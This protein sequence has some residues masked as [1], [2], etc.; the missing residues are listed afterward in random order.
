MFISLHRF[1]AQIFSSIVF[2]EDPWIS[3]FSLRPGTISHTHIQWQV[4]VRSR[5]SVVGISTGYGLDD[6]GVGIRVPVGSRI[7]F[8]PRLP[9]RFWGTPSFLSNRYRRLF[10]QGKSGG[11]VKLTTHLKLVARWRK[12]RFIRPLPHTSAWVFFFL[13]CLFGLWG[14]WHCG[15]SWPI[16]PAS[17][18][19]KDDCGEADGM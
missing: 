1:Q 15:H 3:V 2:L 18:D 4:K 11:G 5:N 17:S 8:S 10:L 12:Y 9:D 7:F 14:Y 16:V 6:Q 13:F 19:S